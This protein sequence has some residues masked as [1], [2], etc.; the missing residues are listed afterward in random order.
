MFFLLTQ[1][2][3]SYPAEL[4]PEEDYSLA[5][6]DHRSED[7]DEV[8]IALSLASSENRTIKTA[9]G[10]KEC[11]DLLKTIKDNSTLKIYDQCCVPT[12]FD[13]PPEHRKMIYSLINDLEI[14]VLDTYLFD[15]CDKDLSNSSL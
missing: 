15:S 11:L 5:V 7:S 6:L 10:V 14:E 9:H 2:P 4:R 8:S 13:A 1:R 3:D 12:S